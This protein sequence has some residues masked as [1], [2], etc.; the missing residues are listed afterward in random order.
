M[1]EEKDLENE[2]MWNSML[3]FGLSLNELPYFVKLK[4]Q[5]ERGDVEKNIME[6]LNF[7]AGKVSRC[8]DNFQTAEIQTA[9]F[10]WLWAN[11]IAGRPDRL[12]R[13]VED[14]IKTL[15]KGDIFFSSVKGD[16]FSNSVKSQEIGLN[17]MI[18]NNLIDVDSLKEK[19]EI[20]KMGFPNDKVA[21]FAERALNRYV[22]PKV[23]FNKEEHTYPLLSKKYNAV[24]IHN[25][26]FNGDIGLCTFECFNDWFV[27]RHKADKIKPTLQGRK[28]RTTQKTTLAVAQIRKFIETITENDTDLKDGYFN[29][30]FQDLKLMNINTAKNLTKE[31]EDKLK[32][33]E[34]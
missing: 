10:A 3:K 27:N 21:L 25:T 5:I 23:E 4:G 20:F 2:K 31:I 29:N 18:E 33:C 30:V 13:L 11:Y 34:N 9:K 17:Y 28:S 14:N 22:K 6:V 15:P 1:K 26:F 7:L 19:I 24:K 16:K 32:L 8:N 12:M